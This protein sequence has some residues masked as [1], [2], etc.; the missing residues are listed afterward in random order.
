MNSDIIYQV[1]HIVIATI[2]VICLK[3]YNTNILALLLIAMLGYLSFEE[4]N[5]IPIYT[6]ISFGL[7]FYL[8]NMLIIESPFDELNMK[9]KTNK[10]LK[11]VWQ[12]PYY[13]IISYYIMILFQNME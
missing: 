8:I 13:G 12:I 11:N 6:L 4:Q 3:K 2:L 9:M 7:G 1:S 10:L 5:N